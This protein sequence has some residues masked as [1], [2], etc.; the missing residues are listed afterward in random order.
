MD[1]HKRK[2]LVCVEASRFA[3]IAMRMLMARSP[4]YDILGHVPVVRVSRVKSKFWCLFR[5]HAFN[6]V[7]HLSYVL[8][9]VVSERLG[10]CPIAC[11]GFLPDISCVSGRDILVLNSQSFE[12]MT[13]PSNNRS[14]FGVLADPFRFHPG[15]CGNSACVA[16]GS[17]Q[18]FIFKSKNNSL[19]FLDISIHVI[20]VG[21]RVI[22]HD[23]DCLNSSSLVWKID[24]FKSVLFLHNRSRVQTDFNIYNY[25]TDFEAPPDIYILLYLDYLYC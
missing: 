8:L 7:S 2:Y 9:V 4:P 23:E 19:L 17:S 18:T 16:S 24:T 13:T 10:F 1:T 15:V 3:L 5:K 20:Y 25:T 14:C 21:Y 12:L 11:R 22:I 6:N